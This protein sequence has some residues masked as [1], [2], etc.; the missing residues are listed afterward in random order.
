MQI[1]E[2]QFKKL[3]EH[4]KYLFKKLPN[5][6]SDEVLAGF[7]HVKGGTAVHRNSGGNTFGGGRTKPTMCDMG[8]GDSGSAARFFYCAKSSRSDRNE[9]LASTSIVKY[10]VPLGGALCKDATMVL[11]KRR[12]KLEASN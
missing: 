12:R 11:N 4:L 5:P 9:G 8:Y 7:P 1:S 10:N 6:G 2:T 3:P